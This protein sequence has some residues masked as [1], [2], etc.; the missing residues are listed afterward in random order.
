MSVLVQRVSGSYWGKYFMPGAAGVGYSHSAYKWYP[1]MDPSAGMLRIVMG[2]GT[3]AVDRTQEDYPRLSN[4]DRPAVPVMTTAA[5]RHKFSP[6]YVD[7]LDCEK[8]AL[9]EVSV[10]TLLPV[11]PL[12]YK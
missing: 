5:Q 6:R 3:K 10:D 12:W 8:N 4:L 11:L 7:V 1:D 9:A 2:L